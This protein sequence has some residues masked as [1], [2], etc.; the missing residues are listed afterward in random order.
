VITLD[1]EGGCALLE[2]YIAGLLM[3]AEPSAS[4]LHYSV[5]IDA[6]DDGIYRTVAVNETSGRRYVISVEVDAPT[7]QE[8]I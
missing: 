8:V 3:R 6:D 5:S 1:D 2:G 4:G 7:I